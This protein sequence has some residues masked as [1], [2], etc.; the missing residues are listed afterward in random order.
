MEE[1]FAI[2][3]FKTRLGGEVCSSD[4]NMHKGHV[5]TMSAKQTFF[6]LAGELIPFFTKLTCVTS[7]KDS[8]QFYLN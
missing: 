4:V 1:N 6:V 2:N 7:C 8:F 5:V 3:N